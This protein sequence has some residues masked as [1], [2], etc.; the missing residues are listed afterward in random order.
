KFYGLHPQVVPVRCHNSFLGD[1][2]RV[3]LSNSNFRATWLADQGNNQRTS[4]RRNCG[5]L[6]SVVFSPSERYHFPSRVSSISS[7]N[8]HSN[9]NVCEIEVGRKEIVGP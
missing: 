3:G 6:W 9:C 4:G 2:F 8:C 1:S 5:D 7:S